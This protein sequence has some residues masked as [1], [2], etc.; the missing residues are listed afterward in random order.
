[1]QN[2]CKLQGPFLK[3][4]GTRQI[5]TMPILNGSLQGSIVG[6]K[7]DGHSGD[8]RLY[9]ETKAAT[10]WLRIQPIYL[11]QSVIKKNYKYFFF[12]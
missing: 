3:E 6:T 8:Y 10:R 4:R 7:K 9:G 5:P 11:T 2:R 12:F 1:M